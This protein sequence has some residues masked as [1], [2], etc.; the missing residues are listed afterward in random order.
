MEEY[1]DLL[2]KRSK[3][4]K[5]YKKFVSSIEK[6]AK[7]V[8]H[9]A[10]VY[11]FGSIVRGEAVGGSDVDVLIVSNS[12]PKENLRKVLLKEKIE[13]LAELPKYHPF[14]IHL[15][16]REEAKWYYKIKDLIPVKEFIRKTQ[17]T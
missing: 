14:E 8:L 13:R 10:K 2:I 16:N 9:D 4:L 1:Y 11:V 6:A 7:R 5:E 3:I 12:I 17:G 15:A